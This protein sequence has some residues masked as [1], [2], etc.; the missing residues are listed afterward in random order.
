MEMG[1]IQRLLAHGGVAALVGG[2]VYPGDLPQGVAMPAI[3]VSRVSG[4][5]VYVDEGESGLDMARA[6]VD[7]C[8]VDYSSAK[9]AAKAVRLALSSFVGQSAGV[10]FECV[11]LDAERDLEPTGSN[12]AEYSHRVSC[13]FVVVYH[14]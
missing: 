4:G 11:L 8:G 6:Q 1:I 3:A 5:P 12:A 9:N 14:P 13:E 2:R 10:S 7:C